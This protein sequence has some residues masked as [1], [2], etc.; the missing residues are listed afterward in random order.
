[1]RVLAIT[2]GDEDGIC[3]EVLS[4]FGSVEMRMVPGTDDL[5]GAEVRQAAFPERET[6]PLTLEEMRRVVLQIA[7]GRLLWE[8][9]RND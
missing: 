9:E 6:S 5:V 4:T 1:V 7:G 3:T 2:D 8:R